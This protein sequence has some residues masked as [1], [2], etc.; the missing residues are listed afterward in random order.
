VD[1]KIRTDTE[2]YQQAKCRAPETSHER[3]RS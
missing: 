2:A 1:R 3:G